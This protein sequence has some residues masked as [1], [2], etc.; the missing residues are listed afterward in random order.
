MHL[1]RAPLI[2]AAFIILPVLASFAQTA[3]SYTTPAVDQTIAQN[4]KNY[5]TPE[6]FDT[7]IQ[8]SI[9]AHRGEVPAQITVSK[10]TVAP[11]VLHIPE[12]SLPPN[13]PVRLLSAVLNS[14]LI[15]VGVPLESRS[16]LTPDQT[17]LFTEY[18]VRVDRVFSAGTTTVATGQSIVVSK[19]GGITM[20]RAVNVTAVEPDFDQLQMNQAYV[21]CLHSFDNT[22]TYVATSFGTYLLANGVA[23]HA[24]KI[25]S[26]HASSPPKSVADF[27]A[28]VE[29]AVNFKATHGS[30]A[31]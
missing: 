24:S 29:A 15:V 20:V 12:S 13:I 1:S 17:F 6:T 23:A 25:E 11:F 16:L 5:S 8:H 21:F 30:R 27:L 22:G 28:A 7:R 26:A 10:T 3:W 18:A 14:Q 2:A 31:Q 4:F 19:P 9:R